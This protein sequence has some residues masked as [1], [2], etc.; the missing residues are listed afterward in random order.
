MH[1]PAKHFYHIAIE[2]PA[3]N[4]KVDQ[5][6]RFRK[7]IDIEIIGNEIPVSNSKNFN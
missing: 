2:I 3:S 6:N 5:I 7:L 4:S 1:Q